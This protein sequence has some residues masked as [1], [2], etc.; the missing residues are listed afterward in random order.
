MTRKRSGGDVVGA[1][2]KQKAQALVW[3]KEA[4]AGHH[5]YTAKTAAGGEYDIT[6]V[7]SDWEAEFVGYYSVAYWHKS[8]GRREIKR[9]V[10]TVDQAKALA[11]ANYNK[12]SAE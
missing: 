2:E 4:I 3:K 5:A 6:P 9:V 8:H 12:L 10:K 7:F 1:P 11:A